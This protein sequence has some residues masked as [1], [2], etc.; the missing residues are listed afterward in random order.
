[1]HGYAVDFI[2]TGRHAWQ[3]GMVEGFAAITIGGENGHLVVE[4]LH[5]SLRNVLDGQLCA[6]DT[7]KIALNHVQ[8]FH[9]PPK[10]G[11]AA[12]GYNAS[13]DGKGL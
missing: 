1:M 6:A 7:G 5:Q 13:R 12:I 2:T 10:V 3:F 8:Y 4:L 9:N 11:K